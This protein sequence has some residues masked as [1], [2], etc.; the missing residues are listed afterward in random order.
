V[1]LM[2]RRSRPT[3]GGPR[4]PEAGPLYRTDSPAGEAQSP[5]VG[6]QRRAEWNGKGCPISPIDEGSE[7]SNVIY[8]KE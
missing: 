4:S 5:P 2:S 8:D 1:R 7:T 3:A 6:S